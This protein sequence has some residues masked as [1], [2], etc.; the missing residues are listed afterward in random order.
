MTN[1]PAGHCFLVRL[2]GIPSGYSRLPSH[3]IPFVDR[4]AGREIT[5]HF[6]SGNRTAR[7]VDATGAGIP[8]VIAYWLARAAFFPDTT[9]FQAP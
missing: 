6:D 8:S 3:E 7:I 1:D 5:V 2:G 4:L 9:V